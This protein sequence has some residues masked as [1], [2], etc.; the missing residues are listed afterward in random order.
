MYVITGATGHTGSTAA[1][2]LL[3][4]GQKVRVI[5]RSADRLRTLASV[6]AE[7][8]VADVTDTKRL[9]EAQSHQ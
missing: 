6:G 7:P 1:R 4:R 2:T 5:G 8:F 3:S 9:T